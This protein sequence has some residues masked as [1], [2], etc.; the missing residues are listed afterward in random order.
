MI[1][2]LYIIIGISC[3]IFSISHSYKVMTEV[4]IKKNAFERSMLDLEKTVQ[5]TPEANSAEDLMRR[6]EEFKSQRFSKPMH[7]FPKKDY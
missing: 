7:K 1:D 5:K 3:L 2:F 6:L 4:K